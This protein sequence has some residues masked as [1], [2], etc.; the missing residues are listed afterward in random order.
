MLL[1]LRQ[2]AS[3]DTVRRVAADESFQD[4]VALKRLARDVVA[5]RLEQ[6]E[7]VA[8]VRVTGGYEPEVQVRLDPERLIRYGLTV[9]QIEQRLRA[10]NVTLPGG[11][12][13]RGPF[14]YA[15]E[16]SGAFTEPADVA[17]TIV[18]YAGRTPL[19]LADVA[20]VRLGVAERRGLVR[21]DGEEALLL[22]V[23][24]AA[25][26]NTVVAARQVHRTL[27]ELEAEV[28]GVRLDVVVDESLFIRHAI[29]GVRQAVLLAVAVAVPLS[30][31]LTLLAFE[32][33][34][35]TLNLLSLSGLALGLGMLV[36]N[37][38]VV[39][40][41]IARLREQGYAS[42]EA[43]R[44]GT[45]EVAAAITASTLT[46]IAVFGP[47]AFVEGL[48][49]RL[50]RDQALAVV[51][52]LLASLLVA[53][54]VV[55]VLAS[56]DRQPGRLEPFGTRWLLVHYEAL[57]RRALRRPGMV[58]L[59]T[60]G[61][62]AGAAV[63]AWRLPQEVMP[64]ADLKR[65]TVHLSAPPGTDLPQLSR[66]VAQIETESLRLPAVRH[67]LADLGERDEARLDLD[68]RPPY[69][70]TLTLLLDET[71]RS[72][73]IAEQLRRM[74]MPPAL[75]VEILPERTQL[76]V[77]LAR[78]EA[79][80]WLD[81]QADLRTEAEAAADRLLSR[82]RQEPALV[83]VRRA[84]AEE[85]P[86][87]ALHFRRDVMARFGVDARQLADWLA[88]A[89]RGL[90]ATALQTVN[91]AIPIRLRLP[92]AQALQRLLQTEIP[93]ARGLKPIGLFVEVQT[94][95]LPA[96]LLRAGQ[97]PVVRLLADVAPEADLAAARAALTR[98]LEALPPG[99]RGTIGGATDAF[100]EGLR[101]AAWSLLLSLLLVFPILAA[102]FESL[103]Q[104]LIILFTV[105]LATIG[106]V[107]TL[108]L[109][110]QSVNLISLTGLVVLVGIVVNDAIIKV[111]F[112]NRR[113]AEGMPLLEAIE[114]AGRDRLR[115]IL[116][117][118]VTT[119][120]GLL[121]L[122]LGLGAGAALQQPLA[123]TIVGGLTSATLLTLI[124]VPVLYVL[125]AGNERRTL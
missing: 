96:S 11:L 19:R 78:G 83:N 27:R 42:L 112:I 16:V 2:A 97:A 4:L 68:P 20:E 30:L 60:L 3:R 47:L 91:E 102:Q 64:H 92:E 51:F 113:R 94:V 107:F 88:A 25:D 89:A 29:A 36:D 6:L 104:P 40:E 56:R 108:T 17:E 43:A 45:V 37:A 98:A 111:D 63:L 93:T 48:A 90:E 31:A 123:I 106:V 59:L 49:G 15:V 86:G 87:Y 125:V 110:G 21:F 33:A 61:A 35:I 122:A 39:T 70:G 5:R 53:L 103:R 8:R 95:S 85:V 67:V 58:L 46:T 69:K 101:G 115:P 52:S 62:L 80:L 118:T 18:G 57:L 120:L 109:T 119:V 100:Q 34:D 41:N 117:T 22:L 75:V 28:P 50:F 7:G 1:A 24:R 9:A 105:P 114:A 73:T 13:R 65:L 38:I 54:T 12:I 84:F 121:P 116:M 74:P 44:E 23:E 76:E 77:L 55:P 10:A 66:W 79:D 81:L 124:V 82:L 71:A 32:V 14:R 26:A 72:E 99:V